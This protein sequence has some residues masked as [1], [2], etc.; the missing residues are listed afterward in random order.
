MSL[1]NSL[2][3][4]VSNPGNV[5]PSRSTTEDPTRKAELAY[6]TKQLPELQGAEKENAID[7]IRSL[8]YNTIADVESK[9]VGIVTP[10]EQFKET[11]SK[12]ILNLFNAPAQTQPSPFDRRDD[13]QNIKTPQV[14]ME[15]EKNE[16]TSP[17]FAELSPARKKDLLYRIGMKK[18]ANVT[19]TDNPF[20]VQAWYNDYY[21]AKNNGMLE[22]DAFDYASERNP[23]PTNASS[24]RDIDEVRARIAF[25]K[26]VSKYLKDPVIERM[27]NEIVPSNKRSIKSKMGYILDAMASENNYIPD[28]YRPLLDHYRRLDNPQDVSSTV[29]E[30]IFATTGKTR[31]EIT[32]ADVANARAEMEDKAIVQ[33]ARKVA[34]DTIARI[35]AE[36][37]LSLSTPIDPKEAAKQGID[38]DTFPTYKTLTD[39]GKRFATDK[40][41]EVYEQMRQAR[42]KLFDSMSL[43]FGLQF[44][45]ETLKPLGTVR[46][47][48]EQVLN[49]QVIG[50]ANDGVFTSIKPGWIGKFK[51]KAGIINERRKGTRRGNNSIEY[52]KNLAD[53]A[54]TLLVISKDTRF[55]DVDVM[56]MMKTQGDIGSS[57][58]DMPDSGIVAYDSVKRFLKYNGD[59]LKRMLEGTTITDKATSKELG[60]D[61]VEDDKLNNQALDLINKYGG[62]Q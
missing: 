41:R 36:R 23:I 9:N 20:Q 11:L 33:S 52:E 3:S 34:T 60:L 50:N 54:R 7:A 14:E 30:H 1:L 18:F 32:G 21:D 39:A 5:I 8:G 46:S 55:S 22:S 49:G 62:Q 61:T 40:E 6:L 16:I 44:D 58:F 4:A 45:P 48:G 26:T 57:L 42:I 29:I 13:S 25:D 53:I 38:L 28:A 31:F 24:L 2:L 17:L 59:Y 35:E 10:E 56:Q 37:G 19:V 27:F 43:M 15:A 12:E 47:N 51:G